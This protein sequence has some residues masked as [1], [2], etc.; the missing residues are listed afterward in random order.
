MKRGLSLLLSILL[1]L[2]VMSIPVFAQETTGETQ[3]ENT[4]SA[5]LTNVALAESALPYA[6]SEKNTLWTPASALND[7]KYSKDTWQGWECGYPDIIYGSDTSA[8]F[9]G[10]Y[11]G[12]KFLNREYYE[13]SEIYINLGLHAAMGNQN[14]NYLVQ[15][16]V[17]GVWVT[18]AEFKD[19]DTK[20]IVTNDDGSFKYSSYDEAMEKDTSFYHIGSEIRVTLD[21]PVTTNNVRITLSDYAKNYPGGDV[22]IFPYI[23]EIELIG[24]RGVTPELELPEGA[25]VSTNIGYH[26]YPEA[27]SS[28]SYKYPYCAIDGK[29]TT[30]WSPK[31]RTAGE[32]LSL[33]FVKPEKINKAVVDFGKFQG[34]TV[35]AS[36]KFAIEAL[37]GGE[38]RQVASGASITDEMMS[39][40]NVED[41][42][43][44]E[45]SF[46]EVEAT[47]IRIVFT[48]DYKK[49]PTVC[50]F[51]A[52]LSV[53]KTYFVEDRFDVYQR[54]SASKGNIAMLGTP[55]ANR[56]FIPYSDV[57]YI[58]DGQ[59]EIGSYVWFT[60]VIDMPS[61]CGVKFNQKQLIDSVALYFYVPAEEGIDVMSIQIQA[62]IDGEYK[63]LVTTKSYN[64]EQKYS[65]AFKFDPVETDDIRILYTAGNG[66]FANMKEIEIYSPNGKAPMFDGL[67]QMVQPP[68]FIDCT[69][70]TVVDD[71][72]G[73]VSVSGE[74]MGAPQNIN[75]TEMATEELVIETDITLLVVSVSV[76]SALVAIIVALL[77]IAYSRKRKIR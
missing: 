47:A 77:C 76:A 2:S 44:R 23:Y 4:E 63:T 68:S 55:Y 11:C 19:S 52:H 31:N 54:T 29:D 39:S 33:V 14:P 66:T 5:E 24:K 8:G 61:Y 62:L 30:N 70:K 67:G 75:V 51:E 12:I 64:K 46:E 42:I 15:C 36:H 3:D 41:R 17:E 73:Q 48:E 32:Y 56:D 71:S 38:W 9:S 28:G 22:L 18:V 35:S 53:D 13:I 6:S 40:L 16:L 65:P 34:A 25:V 72:I 59:A 69:T 26:S 1:L 7:G 45:F 50:E 27:S 37:V 60:G 10:Q 43:Q 21:T 57:N 58:I 74:I 20:P 49:I